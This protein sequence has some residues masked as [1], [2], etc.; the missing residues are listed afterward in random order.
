VARGV[1]AGPAGPRSF[2]LGYLVHLVTDKVWHDLV[3]CNLSGAAREAEYQNPRLTLLV[4]RGLWLRTRPRSR[5]IL[6]EALA[7]GRDWGV[8]EGRLASHTPAA[9]VLAGKGWAIEDWRRRLAHS[10]RHGP[11]TLGLHVEDAGAIIALD[12]DARPY[13]AVMAFAAAFRRLLLADLRRARAWFEFAAAADRDGDGL[14][15]EVAEALRRYDSAPR[16]WSHADRALA[17]G[18]IDGVLGL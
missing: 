2:V 1:G 3:Y 8:M 17:R 15:R 10:I 7:R 12:A 11:E 5:R 6:A 4:D 18:A 16:N 13:P 9:R 14:P